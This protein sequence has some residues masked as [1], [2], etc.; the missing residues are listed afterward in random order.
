MESQGRRG[1]DELAMGLLGG[2]D[3]STG[4]GKEEAM[5]IRPLGLK[6]GAQMRRNQRRGWRRYLHSFPWAGYQ[7]QEQGWTEPAA[8]TDARKDTQHCT[9]WRGQSREAQIQAQLVRQRLPLC[10]C[11]LTPW[12]PTAEKRAPGFI[13]LFQLASF[14][15]LLSLHP[16]EINPR[17]GILK[18]NV[19]ALWPSPIKPFYMITH[20]ALY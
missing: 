16:A 4:T 11:S 14:P 7:E 3:T 8:E 1:R 13:P 5:G 6:G 18:G 2:Q 20:P 12:R 17:P 19:H 15:L 10:Y 9:G